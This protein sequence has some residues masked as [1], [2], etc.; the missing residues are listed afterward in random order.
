MRQELFADERGVGAD[1]MP[2]VGS[3]DVPGQ[4]VVPVQ[5]AQQR[6]ELRDFVR[7]GAD[8][9]LGQHDPGAVRDG[10][11]Q[12]RDEAV[13][14]G[15]S[16]DRLAV[17][18]DGG[19]PA[20]P[21]QGERGRA[22]VCAAGQV[23]PGMVGD[24]LRAQRGQQPDH[25]VRVRRRP[26]AQRVLPGP[27]RGQHLLRCRMHPRGHVLHRGVPAQHCRQ[28]QGQ[29]RRQRVPLPAPVPRVRHRREALQQ[30]PVRRCR[31]RSGP[32]SQLA[33]RF[34]SGSGHRHAKLSRQRGLP[35]G[36]VTSA[37]PCPS[38]DPAAVPAAKRTAPAM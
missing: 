23:R 6:R 19:Q 9:P 22:G 30:V 1:G 10:G 37:I 27:R 3:D 33:Q 20:W 16:A 24:A 15:R 13:R 2:G 18:R 31:Q 35:A 29:H 8:E 11:Q 12:V 38:R 25:G 28:A 4:A 34:L 26:R 21:G 14:A 7:L 32:G 17:H 36:K 5:V